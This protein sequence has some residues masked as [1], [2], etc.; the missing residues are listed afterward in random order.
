MTEV[1]RRCPEEL[2]LYDARPGGDLPGSLGVVDGRGRL[3]VTLNDAGE[4]HLQAAWEGAAL[5][6]SR[7]GFF[8]RDWK[9]GSFPR[10]V[11]G[12]CGR[13]GIPSYKVLPP[14]TPAVLVYR[15]LG[16][17][18]EQSA[19]ASRAWECRSGY[20]PGDGRGPALAPVFLDF[21]LARKHLC[22]GPDS[23]PGQRHAAAAYWFLCVEGDPIL[24]AHEDGMVW[25]RQLNAADLV[26]TYAE[27]HRIWPLV[28]GTAAA[29][30]A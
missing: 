1:T 21:P 28:A 19:F 29:F 24:C 22:G 11:Q 6:V 5:D 4:L 7:G 26:P 3:L 10:L 17:L 14:T 30:L 15:Y 20:L 12:L 27:K 2:R 16:A 18:L 25:D 8:A 23:L 13:L 9:P